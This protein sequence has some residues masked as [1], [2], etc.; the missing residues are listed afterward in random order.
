MDERTLKEKYLYI[1]SLLQ[2]ERL[3]EAINEIETSFWDL[4]KDELA[5]IKTPYQ[6]MLKYMLDGV[7]DPQRHK[8]HSKLVTDTVEYTDKLF[9]QALEKVSSN[10]YYDKRRVETNR[11]KNIPYSS[12]LKTLEGFN[13]ELDISSLVKDEE[14]LKNTL[15][16]HEKAL[17]DLF[18]KTWLSDAWTKGEREEADSI[19]ASNLLIESDLSLFV[20]AVTLSLLQLFD[21]RKVTWLIEAY[22]KKTLNASPRALVGLVIVIHMQ[23]QRFAYYPELNAQI[24]F[25]FEEEQTSD[26]VNSIYIQLLQ[27]QETEKI[28]KKMREEIIPEMI[29]GASTIQD[30]KF[31]FEEG[32]NEDEDNGHNPDWEDAIEKS[33]ISEKLREINDLQMQGADVYMSSF[34]TLKGYPFFNSI[35]NWFYPF[36]KRHSSVYHEFGSKASK[37]GI[38]DLILNSGVFCNSDK[39]SLCFTFQHIPEQQRNL[40]LNQISEEQMGG[41]NEEQKAMKIK[42]LSENPNIIT[43]QYIHDLYR[44][45]KLYKYN[46]DFKDI[47]STSFRLHQLEQFS[48]IEKNSKYLNLL[49]DFF[50]RNE[51]YDRAIEIYELLKDIDELSFELFQKKGYCHQKLKQYDSA[52]TAYIKAD[53]IKADNIWTNR[54]LAFCYRA[55]KQYQKALHYYQAVEKVKPNNMSILFYIGMCYTSLKEYDEALQYFFKIDFLKSNSKRAWRAI[56]W[57]SFISNKLEQAQRYY[58]KVLSNKPLPIDYLNAGHVEWALGDI[59]KTVELYNNAIIG[60]EDK[61]EFINLLYKDKPQ[62]IKKGIPQK[63]IPLLIDLL[64]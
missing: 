37:G 17:S 45:F 18:L 4:P 64:D 14:R 12:L 47:F 13:D 54:H 28:D 6:Y 15:D 49:A 8:L 57:C 5:H 46:S 53:M 24:S 21:A 34:A 16:R 44:F 60:Y 50:L 9:T 40:M 48:F 22:Q 55:T 38:V 63:D 39:Y 30:M 27:G 7:Q 36:E 61:E 19:L 29:K 3:K 11:L 58:Q 33:G 41:L 25:L 26:Q 62:L 35:Q 51:H 43:N 59:K 32:E 56:G 10:I 2:Q 42:E 1:L 20:S 52:I 23:Q 31:G